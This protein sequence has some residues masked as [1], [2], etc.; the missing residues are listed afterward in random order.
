VELE[1]AQ[2]KI[3]ELE[4]IKTELYNS[5]LELEAKLNQVFCKG[6]NRS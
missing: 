6:C 2:R 3:Y 5:K 4:L 1:L